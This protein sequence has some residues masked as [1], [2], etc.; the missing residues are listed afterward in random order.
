MKEVLHCMEIM[1][2]EIVLEQK[3]NYNQCM[4]SGYSSIAHKLAK[5]IV[6]FYLKVNK[7]D[8]NFFEDIFNA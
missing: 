4:G 5:D 3:L 8:L 2:H 6:I 1:Q 7:M